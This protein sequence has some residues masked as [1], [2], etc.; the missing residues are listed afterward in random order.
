[1]IDRY[2]PDR[3]RKIWSEESKFRRW[4]KVELSVMEAYEELGMIPNGVAKLA[5]D[6][7]I[8]DVN[9]ISRVEASVGHD[10]IAFIK[11]ATS[12]MG[13]AGRY[14]HYGLTSSDVVDTALSMAI[15]EATDAI[16]EKLEDVMQ[17]TLKLAK[18]YRNT[19]TIGRT[20]GIHAEPTSFG[21]KVLN[22]YAELERA[23]D[24]ILIEKERISVGKISGAVGNYANV[25]PEVEEIACAK[26]GL[27]PCKIST[28]VIPRD[29]HASYI[30]TLAVLAGGIERIATEIRHL[31]KTEV[32]EVE[33]PFSEK[34]RGS[35]AMPH[36]KNPI[37][38][39]R[40]TGI[41]RM[42]RGYS[43]SAMENI[44]L[45]H[46]RDISHSS[47]ERVIFPDATTLTY[48]A[49][50]ILEYVISG[51]KVNEERLRKN[52]DITKGL[53][54]S[55]KVLLK[56]VEN[57]MSR[58]KAYLV[59]QR[60]SMKVWNGESLDLLSAI[61]E[62]LPN[63]DLEG[64]F[65]IEPYLAHVD[66][67]FDRFETPR[68]LANTRY[69]DIPNQNGNYKANTT[70]K[71]INSVI[72]GLQWG[73]E[74]KG[75]V[76][77]YLSR[78]HDWVV[79]FSGG[80]NAG[81][82]VYHNGTKSIHHLIPSGTEKNKFFIA[83]GTLVDLKVLNDEIHSMSKIFNAF[84][85]NIYI[86]PWCRVITPIERTLDLEIEKLKGPNAV[87]TTGRGI[88]PTVAN[89]AHR[90]AL[91]LFDF[92]DEKRLKEKLKILASISEPLIGTIDVD[93]MAK[94]LLEDFENVRNLVKEIKPNGNVL[95]EGTQ[96]V[97][98][99]PMYGTY[100][101]VTSTACTPSAALYGSGFSTSNLQIWGVF[102]AYTTRVGAGPFPTEVFGEEADK[103]RK[104]GG[105]FGAT[106]GRPRRCGWIDLPLLRYACNVSNVDH[107]IM[108]KADVLNG[109]DRVG[110]CR[111][112][113]HPGM[114]YDLESSNPQIEYIKGWKDLGSSAFSD[115]VSIVEREIGRKVEY[116]SFG[117]E[118][119][120]I[121]R[122]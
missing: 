12:K 22:W 67:I 10:V 9:E 32:R 50:E 73:D 36:K 72:V 69:F 111:K 54:F 71:T 74:G 49:L 34:Q 19:P 17:S 37:L 82:T 18:R 58:E 57:G 90:V 3:M 68:V 96:A 38:C 64:V 91:R 61:R 26:L 1:M 59:V 77:Q 97:M 7:A 117:P 29:L 30:A 100:P 108:T 31:Q 44:T 23:R 101:Y 51:L 48:Y 116:V 75:K 28:Q 40:M 33:E 83:R 99:D 27:N 53:I 102:K 60:A 78:T 105:E 107:L 109:F 65:N 47:V 14:F 25:P 35:S 89:D 110:I 121:K 113:N 46:E 16:L 104:A 86:S 55:Q 119:K 24:R 62:E 80:P 6:A 94:E 95:F 114:P 88:G 66:D 11:V 84:S 106:T 56:L 81:H 112:Y 98:L 45:W 2:T 92:F 63:V 21:L 15:V 43:I 5:S 52:I 41:A 85:E 118:E 79:R 39:E 42:I 103:I 76:T 70:G 93:E 120:D 4:L 87:G 8:V 13:D 115:F 122:I 20:H